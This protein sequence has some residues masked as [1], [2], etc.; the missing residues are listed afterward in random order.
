MLSPEDLVAQR[1]K[2]SLVALKRKKLFCLSG[3]PLVLFW[4]RVVSYVVLQ[5][6]E[7]VVSFHR[8]QLLWHK[9]FQ[10]DNKVNK[11]G[12]RICF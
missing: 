1:N 10:T 12:V 4:G 2:D 5:C 11:K 8:G 7:A 6:C 3:T 9:S